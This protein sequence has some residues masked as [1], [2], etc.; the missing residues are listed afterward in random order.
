MVALVDAF[1]VRERPA[2]TVDAAVQ[3]IERG[4]LGR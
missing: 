1:G 2:R 4:F 3:I